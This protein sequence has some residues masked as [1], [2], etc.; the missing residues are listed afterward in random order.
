MKGNVSR[1]L[2]CDWSVR[3]EITVKLVSNWLKAQ[4]VI[5]VTWFSSE[6]ALTHQM[7]AR[8]RTRTEA[9]FE[10]LSLWRLELIGQI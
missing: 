7:E 6:A 4:D 9:G 3:G 10:L 2:V 5:N 8:I 1:K